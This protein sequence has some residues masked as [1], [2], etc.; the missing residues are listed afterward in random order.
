MK[1]VKSNQEEA[2]LRFLQRMKLDRYKAL[3]AL[4]SRALELSKAE[5]RT[6]KRLLAKNVSIG[7]V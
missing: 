5:L 4:K 6:T 7:Y 2:E 3:E 1:R